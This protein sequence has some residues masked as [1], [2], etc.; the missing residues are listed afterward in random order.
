MVIGGGPRLDRI[1]SNAGVQASFNG[2]GPTVIGAIAGAAIQLVP[3]LE[4]GWQC[5]VLAA[6]A[7]WPPAGALSARCSTPERWGS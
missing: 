4:N 1:R 6:A 5:A 2:A 7:V 3:A